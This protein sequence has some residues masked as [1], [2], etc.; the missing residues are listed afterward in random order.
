MSDQD[1]DELRNRVSRPEDQIEHVY[2]PKIEEQQE[3]IE[4]LEHVVDDLAAEVQ[5]VNQR[6]SNVID[7]DGRGD[8]SPPKRAAALREAMIRA[9]GDSAG[10]LSGGVT[11]WWQ[12]VRDQLASHGHGD[13]SKPVYHDAMKDAA[14]L[15]GFELTTK[16]VITG[17][18]KREVNAIAVNPS[19]VTAPDLRNQLTT[20]D[21]QAGGDGGAA[22][23]GGA[24]KTEEIE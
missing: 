24:V 18:Q 9:C 5:G 15:D 17:G 7:A 10:S 19:K 23:D 8:S 6:V 13:F 12:E 3:Y 21:G 22:T 4:D 16:F 2:A 20:R 11:W 14:D 1:V